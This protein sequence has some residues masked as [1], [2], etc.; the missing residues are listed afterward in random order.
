MEFLQM[1]GQMSGGIMHWRTYD[2][3]MWLKTAQQI[4]IGDCY[5]S[6]VRSFLAHWAAKA[7]EGFKGQGLR[8][9]ASKF[10]ASV[11]TASNMSKLRSLLKK[12]DCAWETLVDIGF[13]D[14]RSGKFIG[15]IFLRL[16]W[17]R[18]QSC[19]VFNMHEFNEVFWGANRRLTE[20]CPAIKDM[21]KKFLYIHERLL[22]DVNSVPLF[23]QL[24]PAWLPTCT[25]HALCD[26]AQTKNKK[27]RKRRIGQDIRKAKRIKYHMALQSH[28]KMTRSH[29]I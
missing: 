21:G 15:M 9:V 25:Q 13:P 27:K 20:L 10:F 14:T 16:L 24:L 17:I 8:R 1:Y 12:S 26:Q 5:T 29:G 6:Y 28:F 4:T 18:F 11:L 3:K 23:V 19:S 2:A 22:S 7:G